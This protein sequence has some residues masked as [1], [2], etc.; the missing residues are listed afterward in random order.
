MYL[1]R[2]RFFLLIIFVLCTTLFY[3]LG[4]FFNKNNAVENDVGYK[5]VLFGEHKCPTAR[6]KEHRK[7]ARKKLIL[8][9]TTIYD[10]RLVF[11]PDR[12]KC[13]E[14]F[15]CE[16]TVDKSKMLQSDAVIF[17]GR[18]LPK[19]NKMPTHL[20]TAK[21]RWIFYTME[22]SYHSKIVPGDYNG[23]FNWTMTYE[24]RADIYEPYGMYA[25]KADETGTCLS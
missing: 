1:R 25:Q 18:D 10:D 7:A 23:M 24:R 9:Y 2:N 19:A 21:Q 20:R 8:F 14:P 15:E 17:H 4:L 11:Y 22:N 6:T 3:I 13:C 16:I 12:L 5:H